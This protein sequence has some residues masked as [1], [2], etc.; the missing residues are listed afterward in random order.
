[1]IADEAKRLSKWFAERGHVLDCE[2]SVRLDG[3]LANLNDLIRFDGESAVLRRPPLGSRSSGSRD[4]AREWQVL[5]R[6]PAAYPLA[7]RGIAYCDDETVIGVPFQI[8]EYREGTAIGAELPPDLPSD[9]P[10]RLTTSL[11][12][13]MVDLHALDAGTVGLETLGHPEGFLARQANSWRFRADAVWP[14]GVPSAVRRLHTSLSA[15]VPAEDGSSLLHMDLKFDNMLIDETNCSATAVIDWDMTTRGN[16][17]FDLAV[18]LAYWVEPN[19]PDVVH[20][21]A[22]VPSLQP[23]FG[24]RQ[25]VARRYFNTSNQ[26][27]RDLVWHVTLA[28]YRLAILWMQLFRAWERGSV[29]G[30]RY[31]GFGKLA[32]A[33][34][35][36]A[37]YNYG[38]GTL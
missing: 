26:P 23:G 24:N 37:E 30:D 32:L 17:L 14:E 12:T 27:E 36:W 25:S 28:R 19:D 1:M 18:L 7:P 20:S 34:L 6:L 22:R 5:S 33:I 2:N 38:K 16:A 31:S 11:L 4:M 9:A 10:D 15:N 13:A 29:Q 35:D 21:L 8:I 3:G